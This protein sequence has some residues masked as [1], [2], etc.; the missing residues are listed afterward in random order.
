MVPETAAS[1]QQIREHPEKCHDR[2]INVGGKCLAKRNET[3]I[4][5]YVH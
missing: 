5:A 4:H 1:Q 2:R 3:L